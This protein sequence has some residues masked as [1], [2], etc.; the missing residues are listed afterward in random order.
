MTVKVQ[1]EN[2]TPINN[3][4]VTLEKGWS[5]VSLKADGSYD[6]EK[7]ANY[8]LTV[9]KDGYNDYKES[10]F[11]FNPTEVNTVKTVTLKKIITRNVRFNITDKSGNPVNDATVTVKKRLL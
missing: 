7:G 11:T 6:M 8:T 3:A 4:N 2:G 5:N 10:S 1:D 9:K